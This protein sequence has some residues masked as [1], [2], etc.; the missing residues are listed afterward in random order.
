MKRFVALLGAVLAIVLMGGAT[1]ASA[2]GETTED[3]LR[4]L[5]QSGDIVSLVDAAEASVN[6]FAVANNQP[7]ATWINIPSNR[8]VRIPE[9]CGSVANSQTMYAF[10]LS[11]S[12]VYIGI[13]MAQ[14]LND[15]SYR[16]AAAVGIAHEFGHHL[17]LLH[18]GSGDEFAVE[19]GA[20]CVAGA[21]LAWFNARATQKLSIEDVVGVGR[22]VKLIAKKSPD[23]PHGTAFDRG[24]AVLKGY[25][26]G[27]PACN[28]YAPTI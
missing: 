24:S 3:L 18:D 20:D 28:E 22:L 11:N 23:D 7:A 4:D 19:D 8:Y 13:D 25:I 5:S 10:C 2:E 27:L 26:G 6:E 1:S 16:L 14:R 9:N 12:T 21:W 17:Q 15:Q